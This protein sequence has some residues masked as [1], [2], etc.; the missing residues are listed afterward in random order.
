[1]MIAS[2]EVVSCSKEF[3]SFPRKREPSPFAKCLRRRRLRHPTKKTGSPE[4][5]N[6]VQHQIK[7][8]P[9][10]ENTTSFRWKTAVRLPRFVA[11]GVRFGKSLQVWIARHR[12]SLVS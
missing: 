12:P 5:S 11:R 6:E 4:L 9:W 1:M 7:V 3:R 10:N 8:L 2:A